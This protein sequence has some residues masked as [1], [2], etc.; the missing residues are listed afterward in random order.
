MIIL[1]DIDGVIAD[2]VTAVLAALKPKGHQTEYHHVTDFDIRY[3][4]P[5][6]VHGDLERLP[7]QE[8]FCRKIDMYPGASAY[9]KALR[10]RGRVI[11]LTKTSRGPFWKAERHEWL[12]Q[13]GFDDRDIV[14]VDRHEDKYDYPG[15]VLIEDNPDTLLHAKQPRKQQMLRPWNESARIMGV[16]RVDFVSSLGHLGLRFT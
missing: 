10:K 5:K 1:L 2:W 8:G 9:L 12:S 6:E 16:P 14:Q 11:A 7:Y 3:C 15:D 4:L 13:R